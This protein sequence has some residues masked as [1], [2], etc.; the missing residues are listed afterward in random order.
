[1]GL[2]ADCQYPTISFDW[3]LSIVDTCNSGIASTGICTIQSTNSLTS[4]HFR[5]LNLGPL[6]YTDLETFLREEWEAG[7]L[8]SWDANDMLSLLHTWQRGDVSL[9]RHGGDLAKCLNEVKAKGLIMP[10]KTDLYFAVRFPFLAIHSI[11]VADGATLSA[12]GQ[13]DRNIPPRKFCKVSDH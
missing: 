6:R 12:G 8:T 10:A 1:M 3:C 7:F 4:L 11:I 2:R 5:D 13:R 9:I